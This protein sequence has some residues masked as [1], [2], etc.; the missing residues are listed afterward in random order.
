[1]ATHQ[2]G[3]DYHVPKEYEINVGPW[4]IEFQI[5]KQHCLELSTESCESYQK[6]IDSLAL[7]NKKLSE[8]TDAQKKKCKTW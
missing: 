1:M 6:Y 7:F 8:T 3:I 4:M 5:A 2:S